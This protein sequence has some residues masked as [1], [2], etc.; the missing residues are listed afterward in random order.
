MKI[1]ELWE[2]DFE[3]RKVAINYFEKF[4]KEMQDI[5]QRH[6]AW[7]G[8]K[9]KGWWYDLHLFD[10]EDGDMDCIYSVKINCNGDLETDFDNE[11]VI[12]ETE[13]LECD[14]CKHYQYYEVE[15]PLYC[16]GEFHG[17][18]GKVFCNNCVEA[19]Q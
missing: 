7:G 16:D 9:Y 11:L 6:D 8:F 12:P 15:E 14:S 18:N 1:K 10:D 19:T 3:F 2:S 5:D 4:K 13:S 17:N